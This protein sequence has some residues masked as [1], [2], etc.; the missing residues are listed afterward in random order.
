[1]KVL[2]ATSLTQGQRDND[3]NFCEDGELVVLPAMTCSRETA[4]GPCGCARSL[5]GLQSG[6]ATTTAV[7]AESDLS[8]GEWL[9]TVARSY[10]DDGWFADV[11]HIDG[12]V[13]DDHRALL[14]VIADM[15]LG[16]VVEFRD[17]V[18]TARAATPAA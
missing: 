13:L 7:V 6:R 12:A 5:C 1:M 2:F 11:A 10:I 14:K 18:L 3:F 17:D 15:P 4:D 9:A 8:V 16:T